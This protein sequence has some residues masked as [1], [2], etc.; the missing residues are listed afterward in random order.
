MKFWGNS[1]KKPEREIA[2]SSEMLL[3]I[4]CIN[5]Y[6]SPSPGGRELKGGGKARRAHPHPYPLPLR[7]RDF[8]RL[9]NSIIFL[10]HRTKNY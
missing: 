8:I 6:N 2:Q 1:K 3:I 7:E 10:G 5:Y 9:L 4:D